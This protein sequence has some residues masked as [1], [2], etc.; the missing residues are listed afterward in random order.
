[1]VNKMNTLVNVSI[2]PSY[3]APMSGYRFIGKV[4]LDWRT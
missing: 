1:M 4:G 2:K 3:F